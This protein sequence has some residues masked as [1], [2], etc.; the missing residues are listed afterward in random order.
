MHNF[1]C[2]FG[3]LP[4]AGHMFCIFRFIACETHVSHMSHM[5]GIFADVQLNNIE[6]NENT[7]IFTLFDKRPA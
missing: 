1:T 2:M 6:K 3:V 4:H 7:D 5:H